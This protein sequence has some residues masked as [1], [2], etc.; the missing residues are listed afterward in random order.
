M[1]PARP[2]FA[3]PARAGRLTAAH[4]LRHLG[5]ACTAARAIDILKPAALAGDVASL[6][7]SPDEVVRALVTLTAPIEVLFAQKDLNILGAEP[8]VPEDGRMGPET[9]RAIAELQRHFGQPVTG[10]LD[11]GAAA[12]LRYG[13]GCIY[14]QDQASV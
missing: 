13:A 4:Y 1:A 7:N 11:S 6:M 3:P 5:E 8:P 9:A 10:K 12:A 2:A 14:S